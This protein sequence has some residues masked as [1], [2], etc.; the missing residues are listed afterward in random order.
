[1]MN[2]R[3]KNINRRQ[4]S[5]YQRTIC[6]LSL[7]LSSSEATNKSMNQNLQKTRHR[8]C[9]LAEICPCFGW[10]RTKA[11]NWPYT[12]SKKVKLIQKKLLSAKPVACTPTGIKATVATLSEAVSPHHPLSQHWSKSTSK[13]W[14]SFP[15]FSIQ[16]NR[17]FCSTILKISVRQLEWMV[18]AFSCTWESS[19]KAKLH[20]RFSQTSDFATR[21]LKT[22]SHLEAW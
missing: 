14:S 4:I 5:F 17:A 20:S 19:K 13:K 12:L 18:P 2:S 16:K 22:S 1:M 10:V 6:A 21:W 11:I 3:L 8:C 15:T 9:L 7:W